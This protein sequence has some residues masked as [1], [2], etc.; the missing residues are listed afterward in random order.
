[1]RVCEKHGIAYNDFCRSC[2]QE[3]IK[4]WRLVEKSKKQKERSFKKKKEWRIK[5]NN[6]RENL[7]KRLQSAW[8]A[9]I[10]PFYKKL[11]LTG[12]CWICGKAVL[13]GVKGL[14]SSQ[15]SHYYAKSQVYQL[16]SHP[17]NSGI[18]CYG[19]NVDRPH[20][21]TAMETKMIEVWGE[22]N[23]ANLK[24]EHDLYKHAID[25]GAYKKHP[26][27]EWF[28]FEIDSVKNMDLTPWLDKLAKKQ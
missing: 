26:P 25:I 12:R 7:K 11:G 3:N 4:E 10:F 27:E 20:T 21:V 23:V 28:F 9:K 17:V 5:P 14:Y 22:K 2:N 16:W 1:M 13:E 19:C 6:K 18:C 8:R 15:V 24:D